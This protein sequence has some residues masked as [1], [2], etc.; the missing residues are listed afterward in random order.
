MKRILVT[1]AGGSAGINFISSIK[2][3]KEEMYIV[4]SDIN[5]YHIELAP[6][7]R[8]YIMP[9]ALEST[10]IDKLN[11]LIKKEKIEFV[12]SQPDIEVEVISKNRK[13]INALTFLPSEKTIE[14][15]HNKIDFNK[16]MEKANVSVPKSFHIRSP[17]DVEEALPL[18][19]KSYVKAWTRA[20]RG[21][22]SRAS[23]PVKTSEHVK[24]WIEW[25]EMMREVGYGDF[26]L[27]EFLPGKEF[28]WQ[29]VWKDGELITS[30]ARE[31]IEYLFGELTPSGQ[32]ST[33]AIAK[34]VH[35]GDVNEVATKSVQAI[36][37]HANGIFC[38]DI[39]ENN[40]GVPC[41]T[42]INAGRF[43]TTSNFFAEAG[44]NMPYYYVKLAYG[45]EIPKLK[46]Y[47]PLPQNLYWIRVIDGGY[48]L[49]QE[50]KWSSKSI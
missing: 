43:F 26:M 14:L 40:K 16:I 10:Y 38:V 42:E 4:G 23:L 41:V 50:G 34:T 28:A 30:Q 19:L 21:A 5:K 48:K 13:K 7:D 49:V 37:K 12:H 46:K 1:G 47:N 9:R 24:F 36:D 18:L 35:R 11:D 44:C 22:G 20:I 8:K 15:C 45:E 33:P 39:K 32:T 2:L 27:S 6:V 3:A 17:D 29:S 31:R 25:W